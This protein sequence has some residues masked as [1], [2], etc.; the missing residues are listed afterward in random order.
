MVRVDESNGNWFAVESKSF[1]LTMEGKGKKTKCYITER[2]RGVVS[3]IRFGVEGM[4]KLLMGVEECCRVFDPASS[5]L[6][7]RENGRSF[8]LESKVN[9]AGRFLLCSVT[10][11]EGKK[12]WLVFPEGRGF[13][14]GWSMLA[15]KISGLGF[16]PRVENIPR[17]TA[18][19]DPS[20]RGE[21]CTSFRKNIVTCEGKSALRDVKEGD[22]SVIN[23]V[24][25]DVGDCIHGK[26]LG[27]L[28]SCLIGRWKIQ[29]ASYPR[30]EELETWFR[31]AW[32]L[33]KEV[34]LTVLNEDLMLL[35][36]NSPEEA[37]WVIESGRRSFKGGRIQLD[38][39]S[40]ETG[41]IRSRGVVRE[42]WIRV[43]GLPLHLWTPEIL[44]KIG[45]ACGGFVT[46]DKRTEMKKEM[47]WARMLI[48]SEGKARPST[49]NILEGLRSYELQIWWEF[50][51]WVTGVY[52]AVSR[53]AEKDP[54]EEDEVLAR[55]AKRVGA[56]SPSCN[57][58]GRLVQ[59]CRTEKEEGP[60]LVGAVI[61][62]SE[63][64][65]LM[66]NINGA[67]VEGRGTKRVGFCR[68][69]DGIFQQN[70]CAD[71]P[72]VRVVGS[73]ILG[74]IFD[75]RK[76]PFEQRG[77]SG[78]LIAPKMKQPHRPSAATDSSGGLMGPVLKGPKMVGPPI[79][80]NFLKEGVSGN[81]G[82]E[83]VL[84]VAR[85]SKGDTDVSKAENRKGDEGSCQRVVSS[86]ESLADPAWICA[87]DSLVYAQE[88]K[89]SPG[90]TSGFESCWEKGLGAVSSNCSLMGFLHPGQGEE[91]CPAFRSFAL[92]E[93]ET[94]CPEEFDP[95]APRIH[96]KGSR[97]ETVSSNDFSPSIFSVFGRPLLSGGSSG[98]GESHEYVDLGEMELL[99]VV[100]ADGREWGKELAVVSME[101]GQTAMGLGSLSDEPTVVN[102]EVKGYDTWEDSCLIKFSEFLGVTTAGFEEEILELMRKMDIRQHGDNRKGDPAETRCERELRKLECTTNYNGK[103][104]NRGGRDR[105]N[106]LLK[107]K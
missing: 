56:P 46:E 71:G 63:A 43:V 101:G 85:V 50:P 74:P 79:G 31:D 2:S 49:V 65:A 51:P 3:W 13:I 40:P 99:R 93:T 86:L 54:K 36:F 76:S 92:V 12:H 30:T 9:I 58:E 17:R 106:F 75:K 103:G 67:H 62:N 105:G 20:K 59:S 70:G 102:S 6:A 44:R 95:E 14:N 8:R 89:T 52:P 94:R 26:A 1:E 7:W 25:V 18:T 60:G 39:W 35:E 37:K 45:D 61:V 98:L 23:T 55:A 15:E 34:M 41:C 96:A 91:G 10:D 66:K 27:S 11:G 4:E 53:S 28:Q 72:K 80:P 57:D 90:G 104:Q 29:P 88:D 48:K 107:L 64:G 84:Y 33:N 100:S 69:G 47:K 16:K 81:R 68:L 82:M 78:L 83:K 73:K 19:L 42:T 22:R 38:W 97:F 87:R 5:S 77:G 24:W 32:R 21:E